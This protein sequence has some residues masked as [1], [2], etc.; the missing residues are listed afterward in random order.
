[1]FTDL[2]DGVT[3]DLEVCIGVWLMSVDDLLDG[4]RPN[5][6]FAVSTL[7]YVVSCYPEKRRA[8]YAS[9]TGLTAARFASHES[10]TVG[11]AVGA[12]GRRVLLSV[13]WKRQYV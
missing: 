6:I 7:L 3:I 12:I 11:T 2:T 13:V 4:H 9:S 10:T 5:G 1:M 8:T